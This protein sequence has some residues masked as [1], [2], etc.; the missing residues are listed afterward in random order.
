MAWVNNLFIIS[1]HKC[2]AKSILRKMIRRAC[3]VI[4]SC[5]SAGQFAKA[6]EFCGASCRAVEAVHGSHSI[7]LATELHKL[8]QLLFNRCLCA[9]SLT[10]HVVLV[11]HC[12][13]C[14]YDL[15]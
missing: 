7:E 13:H 1:L 2:D 8:A 5:S 14:I 3:C 9:L 10:I 4:L 15:L 11:L 12:R 6:A